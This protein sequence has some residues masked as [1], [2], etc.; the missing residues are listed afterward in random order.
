MH[1]EDV[2]V[3]EDFFRSFDIKSE[4]DKN[5]KTYVRFSASLLTFSGWNIPNSYFDKVDDANIE[6]VTIQD[7]TNDS[8]FCEKKLW[9]D[10]APAKTEI[11]PIQKIGFENWAFFADVPSFNFLKNNFPNG[12]SALEKRITVSKRKDRNEKT[13]DNIL[14]IS[15]SSLNNFFRCSAYWL[16]KEIFK[17]ESYD[18][19]A[20]LLDDAG[21]GLLY[22][23]IL[24]DL[25]L[26]IKTEDSEFKEKNINKYKDWALLCAEDAAKKYPSFR[27]PLAKPLIKAMSASLAG[28]INKMLGEEAKNYNGWT[29]TELEKDY[30][31]RYS[32][33]IILH[34]R[35]DRV[36]VSSDF[37]PLIID[38]KTAIAP[39]K[40]ESVNSP[41]NPLSDFQIPLYIKLYECNTNVQVENAAFFIINSFEFRKIIK[42]DGLAALPRSEYQETLDALDIFIDY[43]A[44]AVSLLDFAPRNVI[45]KEDLVLDF[46][47]KRYPLSNCFTCVYKTICRTSYSLGAGYNE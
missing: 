19:N 8:F 20:K 29:V 35:I 16:Y 32:D 31:T 15:A 27:G 24:K 21:K 30:K 23:E 26:R 45:C 13:P 22:H 14:R 7:N 28:R 36:S 34:G 9:E 17:I 43:Y 40:K 37:I 18:L 11:L 4:L 42:T 44:K 47:K 38:Y 3:C 41:L 6:K 5:K 12:F 2:D 39:S 46:S 10:G 33:N 25:F 1:L